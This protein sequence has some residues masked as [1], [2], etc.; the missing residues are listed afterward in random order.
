MFLITRSTRRL[1]LMASLL[2]ISGCASGPQTRS[3]G[4]YSDLYSGVSELSFSTLMPIESAEEGVTR[5]DKAYAEGKVDL[6]VFEYIRSLE[7]DPGNADTFYK[8]GSINFQKKAMKK[9][10][11]AFRLSLERN[12]EHAGSLEG[13]GL[14]LMQRRDYKN[15]RETLRLATKHDSQRWMSYNALGILADLRGDYVVARY[16]YDAALHVSP[17]NAQVYNNLG[18]SYYLTGNW[19]KAENQYYLALNADPK[20][21]RAWRN[22]G[23]LYTRREHYEEAF[24]AFTH[25][26]DEA[27][28]YNTIGYICMTVGRLE[29]AEAF[30]N[31]AVRTSPSY[32][33]AANENLKQLRR[34]RAL[35]KSH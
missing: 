14:I 5:G 26:M 32:Y 30:F 9:A 19:D 24:D 6:A 8:I 15:A 25:N 7:L 22:L 33:V 28:A 21:E 3:D 23:Q 31:K 16:Y 12:P 10:E 34:L 1:A 11:S 4:Q 27:A 13:L 29:K 17:R 18:Y 35:K 2:V 20:H